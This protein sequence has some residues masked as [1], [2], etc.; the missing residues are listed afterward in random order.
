MV[1]FGLNSIILYLN[2]YIDVP[3][4]HEWHV[5]KCHAHPCFE[6]VASGSRNV[7]ENEDKIKISV[8]ECISPEH[9]VEHDPCIDAIL[10]DTEES[11]KVRRND[12]PKFYAV[13]RRITLAEELQKASLIEGLF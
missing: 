13:Y 1:L 4:L 9:G 6:L 10:E 7:I 12:G 3:E 8:N 5:E 11:K 2:T